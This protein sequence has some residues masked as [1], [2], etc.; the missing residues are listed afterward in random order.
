MNSFILADICL[1]VQYN[2]TV[3]YSISEHSKKL[4]LL[5]MSKSHLDTILK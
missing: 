4:F 5:V 2:K 1:S 3:I